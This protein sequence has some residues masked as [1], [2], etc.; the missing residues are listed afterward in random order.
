LTR[1]GKRKSVYV[2]RDKRTGHFVRSGTPGAIRTRRKTVI[3]K[4]VFRDPKTGK[5]ASPGK[6]VKNRRVGRAEFVEI[7]LGKTRRGERRIQPVLERDITHL[8]AREVVYDVPFTLQSTTI[9]IGGRNRRRK[10]F[11]PDAGTIE[12]L[13]VQEKALQDSS[14]KTFHT[15]ACKIN[16]QF[17][18]EDIDG[19][20]TVP[21]GRRI[22]VDEPGASNDLYTELVKFLAAYEIAAVSQIQLSILRL[23]I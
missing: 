7:P 23:P 11:V 15:A 17:K 18:D 16:L 4:R 10:L 8:D 21:I 13:F 12:R 2:F 6:R 19:W 22:P 5:F 14:G 1:K 9:K 3:P 20:V